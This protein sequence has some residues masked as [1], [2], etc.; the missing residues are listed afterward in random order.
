MTTRKLQ[1]HAYREWN[2]SRNIKHQYHTFEYYWWE[3]YARVCGLSAHIR[4]SDRSSANL[5][6]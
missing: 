4:S 5:L 2:T 6:H 3:R 1:E